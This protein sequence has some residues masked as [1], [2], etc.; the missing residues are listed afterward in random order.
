MRGVQDHRTFPWHSLKRLLDQREKGTCTV[1]AATHVKWGG[2]WLAIILGNNGD[3]NSTLPTR[4][5]LLL[6]YTGLFIRYKREEEI[7]MTIT[8]FYLSNT[9]T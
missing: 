8:P 7:C 1:Y 4:N 2:S 6:R 3:K 9:S 5:C